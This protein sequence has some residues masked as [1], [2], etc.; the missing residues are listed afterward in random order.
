MSISDLSAISL[1]IFTVL[2]WEKLSSQEGRHTFSL[3]SAAEHDCAVLQGDIVGDY[4]RANFLRVGGGHEEGSGSGEIVSQ[5][6]VKE[7]LPVLGTLQDLLA[8]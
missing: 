5:Y 6:L 8:D 2:V 1:M 3:H 7:L 4:A